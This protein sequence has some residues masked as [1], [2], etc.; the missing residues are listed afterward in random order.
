MMNKFIILALF[1]VFISLI[2]AGPIKK[3]DESKI[4]DPPDVI[5]EKI[6]N[7]VL[8]EKI[9]HDDIL[10]YDTFRALDL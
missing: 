8:K 2:M 3:C 1:A 5:D 7:Y 4:M 10:G 9:V 6:M